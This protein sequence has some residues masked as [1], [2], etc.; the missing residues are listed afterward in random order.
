MTHIKT[1]IQPVVLRSE[2]P[3]IREVCMWMVANWTKTD[4]D[5]QSKLRI[6]S[7]VSGSHVGVL[8]LYTSMASPLLNN[9][10]WSGTFCRIFRVRDLVQ[11]WDFDMFFTFNFSTIFHL[12]TWFIEWWVI[13]YVLFA[14]RAHQELLTCWISLQ[15]SVTVSYDTLTTKYVTEPFNAFLSQE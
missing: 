11:L 14:W 12:L 3:Q 4:W 8:Q 1:A 9:V 5:S 7:L 15:C 2:Q 13:Q 10:I 6:L